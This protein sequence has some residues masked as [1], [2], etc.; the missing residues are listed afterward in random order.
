[1]TQQLMSIKLQPVNGKLYDAVGEMDF[2]DL[3]S[4]RRIIDRVF[5]VS[6][7]INK[8]TYRYVFEGINQI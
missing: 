5:A 3:Y 6:N 8:K 4:K 7:N 2:L 1:M